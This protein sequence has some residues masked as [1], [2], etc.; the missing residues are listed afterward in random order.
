VLSKDEEAESNPRSLR[1]VSLLGLDSSSTLM[2]GRPLLPSTVNKTPATYDLDFFGNLA[3]DRS[4]SHLLL[5]AR[6]LADLPGISSIATHL[7]AGF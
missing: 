2:S 1:T 3:L 4:S 7:K 5:R 6:R